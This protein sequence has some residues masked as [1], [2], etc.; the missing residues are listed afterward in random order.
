MASWIIF[1]NLSFLVSNP[2]KRKSIYV[3]L[4]KKKRKQFQIMMM[5]MEL[6][7]K[8][9]VDYVFQKVITVVIKSDGKK[10][11]IFLFLF[12]PSCMHEMLED[13]IKI[14]RINELIE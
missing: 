14:K 10:V 1:S 9:Q 4:I 8:A 3:F 2:I 7:F 5:D 6:G 12:I 11:F 13:Y